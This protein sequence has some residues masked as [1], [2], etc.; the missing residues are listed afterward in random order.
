MTT[1]Q[2][3]FADP[4]YWLPIVFIALTGIS[5]LIYTVLDGYDLGVGILLLNVDDAQRDQMI[6]SIGPF[7]DANE[8]WLVLAVG[9]LLVAFPT[10][11]GVVLTSLYIPVALMLVGLILRG[12]SFEFRVKAQLRQKTF[13]DAMFFVGS[14]TASLTQGY[15]LG[16]YITG[17]D[18][19]F[20]AFV[21]AGI[22]AVCVMS[23]YLLIGACWLI[24]KTDGEL[25][26]RA[27]RWAKAGL[28]LTATG[29]LLV[30]IVNPLVSERIFSKWF[31]FPQMLYLAPL[32]LLSVAMLFVIYR[33][34]SQLPHPQDH[35]CRTPFFAAMTLFVAAFFG[36]GYS[37][38][39]YVVPEQLTIWDSASASGS[40]MIILWGV[41]FVLP[42]II[43]YTAFS[44]RV[45]R[46]KARPLQ[47]Y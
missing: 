5:I 6:S 23:A 36:L 10:A 29:M 30:S 12:V 28:V 20:A 39:P 35:G 22:S 4:D 37:F 3:L 42:A 32:P 17:F 27:V 21:F 19:S 2:T 46:G 26:I 14:M 47:Y 13:W 34:L 43:A 31:S 1:L 33:Q 18:P 16:R 40:L 7:W 45:F 38:Y 24:M 11:H 8:T 15:M 41:V 9:L 25:Q 44:Y